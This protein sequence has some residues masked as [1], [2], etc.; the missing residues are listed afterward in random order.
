MQRKIIIS[1]LLIMF[2]IS[3]LGCSKE[4]QDYVAKVNDQV[5]TQQE[6]DSRV[7][8]GAAM[9]NFDLEAPE[10]AAYKDMFKLQILDRMI[11]ELL[12]E[13]EAQNVHNLEVK[14]EEVEAEFSSI[15]DQFSSQ[16]EFTNYFQDQLKMTEQDIKDA[17]KTQLLVQALYEEVTKDITQSDVDVQK[18]YEENKDEFYQE[19][20]VK[21]RHILVKTE[22]EAREIIRLITE[23]NED[24]AELAVL[25]SIE[26]AAKSSKGDLGYFGRGY[27]VK[28]FEDA[29]FALEVDEITKEPVQTT[30]GYHVIRVEDR[31]PAKQRSFDE[32]KAELEERFLYEAKSDAFAEYMED[33]KSKAT[34]DN[35]LQKQIDEEQNKAQDEAQDNAG[36]SPQEE[37]QENANN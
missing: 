6:F 8:Q 12:L 33:L 26:P 2:I 10:Y 1:M 22:E 20:Q 9:N 28:P 30:F 32:V 4:S 15:K 25:K 14:Q 3:A 24:M 17:I 36:D 18:Y 29:A 19:E 34:I 7:D 5:I 21:A 31:M 37:N 11:D 13:N 16:E 23:E 27:M 35:K